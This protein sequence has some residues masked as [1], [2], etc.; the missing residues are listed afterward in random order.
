MGVE[1]PDFLLV[2][3]QHRLLHAEACRGSARCYA[4]YGQAVPWPNPSS[5]LVIPK[6]YG[7]QE[8]SFPKAITKDARYRRNGA[9]AHAPSRHISRELDVRQEKGQAQ[10]V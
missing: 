10:S 3:S 4:K 8:A 6:T 7:H 1:L 9:R 5:C 2:R